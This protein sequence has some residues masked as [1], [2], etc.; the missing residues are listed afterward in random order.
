VRAAG[1]RLDIQRLGVLPVNPVPDAT[2]PREVEQ[3]LLV[4]GSAGHVFDLAISRPTRTQILGCLFCNL[5]ASLC[6][7]TVGISPIE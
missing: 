2:Q 4:G 1:E 5:P 3:M 7:T 6:V